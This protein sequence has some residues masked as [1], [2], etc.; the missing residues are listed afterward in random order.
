MSALSAFTHWCYEAT[1]TMR[2][3]GQKIIKVTQPPQRQETRTIFTTKPRDF[4]IGQGCVVTIL[5][6]EIG[7]AGQR[8]WRKLDFPCTKPVERGKARTE[9]DYFRGL[10][11]ETTPKV[12]FLESSNTQRQRQTLH[13][14]QTDN[15]YCGLVTTGNTYFQ[16]WPLY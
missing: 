10:Q 8:F 3:P 2:I 1:T 6:E 9:A 12:T 13:L 7:Q 11:L 14:R 5:R 4:I 16:L 15:V